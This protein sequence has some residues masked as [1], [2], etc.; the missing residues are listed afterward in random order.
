MSHEPSPVAPSR[1]MQRI[2]AY[3]EHIQAVLRSEV[4]Q[5]TLTDYLRV[6]HDAP[7]ERGTLAQNGRPILADTIL[8]RLVISKR[9]ITRVR[10][11]TRNLGGTDP[12]GFED[13]L[14]R[15]IVPLADPEAPYYHKIIEAVNA[16][17]DGAIKEHLET[18]LRILD[19]YRQIALGEQTLAARLGQMILSAAQTGDAA[20]LNAV[21]AALNQTLRFEGAGHDITITQ[22]ADPDETVID[23]LRMFLTGPV[24]AALRLDGL[25]VAC[26]RS[27]GQVQLPLHATALVP[28]SPLTLVLNGPVSAQDKRR[29]QALLAEAPDQKL[30]TAAQPADTPQLLVR[31]AM[32][33]SPIAL[34]W[35]RTADM[36]QTGVVIA[37]DLPSDATGWA[38]HVVGFLADDATGDGIGLYRPVPGVDPTAPL[39]LLL[40]QEAGQGAAQQ[41]VVAD[42]ALQLDDCY[43]IVLRL[44]PDLPLAGYTNIDN[45]LVYDGLAALQAACTAPQPRGL[46]KPVVIIGAASPTDP[47]RIV[48]SATRFR[49]FGSRYIITSLAL[50]F[51][52]LTGTLALTGP[53]RDNLTLLA[54]AEMSTL[55][56]ARLLEPESERALATGVFALT[57]GLAV[58]YRSLLAPDDAAANRLAR[59]LNGLNATPALQEWL[60]GIGTPDSTY[61][62]AQDRIAHWP[63]EPMIAEVL[64]KTQYL[65]NQIEKFLIDP[66][67]PTAAHVLGNLDLRSGE[68]LTLAAEI[69]QFL[70]ALSAAP[71]VLLEVR[72]DHIAVALDAARFTASADQIAANLAAYAT[73][74]CVTDLSLVTPLFEL[75]ACC[76]PPQSVQTALAFA[77]MGKSEQ[78]KYMHRIADCV[79]RFGDETVMVQV[80]IAVKDREPDL[81]EDDGFL[82][83]FQKLAA[84]PN[85]MVLRALFGD[86]L[87]ARIES[88]VPFRDRFR[89]AVAQANRDQIERLVADPSGDLIGWLD[90]LRAFSSDLRALELNGFEVP[91]I[92]GLY[93]RKL[94][95]VTFADRATISTFAERNFLDGSSDLDVIAQHLIGNS[96]PLNQRV[97]R[98]FAG[99]GAPPFLIEG[100]SVAQVFSRAGAQI[101]GRPAAENPGD[102]PLVSVIIS[103]FNPDIDLLRLSLESVLAQSHAAIEVFIVDDASAIEA[104]QAIR[105][106]ASDHPQVQYLR[107]DHNSGPYAGRNLA[108]QMARGPFVAIQDADDWSHPD[109]FTAQLAAFAADPH[110]QLVTT[111]HVR[112][113]RFGGVQMEAGFTVFGDGPMTSMFRSSVFAR[114]GGFAATRSRGDV[115]MRERI[116]ACY[117]NHAIAE[118]GLPGML[119]FADSATLS[120]RIRAELYEYLQLFRTNFG[121]RPSMANLRRNGQALA[122]MNTVL[123]PLPLRS[124]PIVQEMSQ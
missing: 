79:R 99:T 33:M 23:F 71:S 1:F 73:Y 48:E 109:R 47:N 108:L 121:R 20:I 84:S 82:S 17:A 89:V 93:Q 77:A 111:P 113:D 62:A 44:D 100:D 45:C 43:A 106:L 11:F 34:A 14:R 55:P 68:T 7:P 83:C 39:R 110:L 117:G 16:E 85:P 98:Q 66:K 4:T 15:M 9:F 53:D 119:C 69:D 61:L 38:A 88:T 29:W 60:F 25:D 56:L 116:R 120:H 22:G 3:P 42:R 101:A 8:S 5:E 37:A 118:L 122:A 97:A 31:A 40:A 95:A 96:A 90:G 58:C 78:R 54:A 72:V 75:L 123:V 74:I 67:R 63:V 70:L 41:P 91:D 36:A 19:A 49:A 28:P 115:E 10:Q 76:L 107:T 35:L 114:I 112:I 94:A 50:G 30:G 21:L 64:Q 92:S 80:L 103:A 86:A 6:L 81:L 87:L 59:R 13:V 65:R 26:L 46:T 18:L 57:N 51:D 124:A 12:A 2:A 104:S 102:L 27:L 105:G 52:G 24:P 32:R